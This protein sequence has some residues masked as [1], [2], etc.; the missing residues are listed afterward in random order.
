MYD[1][2]N[3]DAVECYFD[4]HDSKFHVKVIFFQKPIKQG[5]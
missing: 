1:F 3:A 2:G 4:K 5:L